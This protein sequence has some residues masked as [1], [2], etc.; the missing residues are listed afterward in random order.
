MPEPLLF[1]DLVMKSVSQSESLTL[2]VLFSNNSS[3]TKYSGML[4]RSYLSLGVLLSANGLLCEAGAAV[5]EPR[6]TPFKDSVHVDA[7]SSEVSNNDESSAMLTKPTAQSHYIHAIENLKK[8]EYK[9]ALYDV[10]LAIKENPKLVLAYNLRA[11]IYGLLGEYGK[12]MMD[13]K[14]AKRLAPKD[15]GALTEQGIVEIRFANYDKAIKCFKEANSIKESA[16]AI[17]SCGTCLLEQGKIDDAIK[18]YQKAVELDP[19]KPGN[20]SLGVAYSIMGDAENSISNHTIN[21]E[22]N[23]D[24]MQGYKDR[25]WAYNNAGEFAKA[26]ADCSK[27]IEINKD[28]A[29]AYSTRAT[30]YAGLG[31]KKRAVRDFTKALSLDA[32]YLKKYGKQVS[33]DELARIYLRRAFFDLVDGKFEPAI[34]ESKKVVKMAHIAPR[35]KAM[36]FLTIA[37]ANNLLGRYEAALK[38]STFA[39]NAYPFPLGGF[40]DRAFAYEQIGKPALAAKDYEK[41]AQRKNFYDGIGLIKPQSDSS[42]KL[43]A[44]G[45]LTKDGFLTD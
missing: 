35:I 44:T 6:K 14:N 37:R 4:L 31:Q 24:D 22:A 15:I 23:K 33:P 1:Y 20:A 12:A 8:K 34:N 45:P 2:K 21:I 25:A 5:I 43:E 27:A 18:Q 10:S 28:F 39:I 42:R 17:I 16:D 11:R 9:D 29:T 19:A 26:I 41:A 36:A 32:Q 40:F 38:N 3:A 30:A 13:L 7:S